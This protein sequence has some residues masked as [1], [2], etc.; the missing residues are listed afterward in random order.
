MPTAYYP[1]AKKDRN[2]PGP[3]GRTNKR[4]DKWSCKCDRESKRWSVCKCIARKAKPGKRLRRKTVRIDLEKKKK[5]GKLW[6]RYTKD[7]KAKQ[8][9]ASA[10]R[11]AA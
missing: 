1:F 4:A 6:R 3:K 8:R 2:G 5:Y 11:S 7:I 9:R 10:K